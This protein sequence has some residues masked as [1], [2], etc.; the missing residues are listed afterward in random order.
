MWRFLFSTLIEVKFI[1]KSDSGLECP[2]WV[3]GSRI[4]SLEDRFKLFQNTV[5]SL[6]DLTRIRQNDRKEIEGIEMEISTI[7]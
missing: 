4:G 1:D 6:L 7:S 3:Q 2:F 5:R